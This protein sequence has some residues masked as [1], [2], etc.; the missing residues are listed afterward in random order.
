VDDHEIVLDMLRNLLEPEFEIVGVASCGM[1][2]LQAAQ[3]LHPDIILLDVVMPGPNGL[4]VGQ[5]LRASLP[6]VKLVYLT[7]EDDAVLAATAFAIGASGFVVKTGSAAELQ[8]AM[9]TVVDGKRYLSLE[10]AHGDVE[11]LRDLL[12]IDPIARLTSRELEVLKLLLSGLPMKSV[13]RR[14]GITP[15]TVAFHKYRAMEDLG[16][17]NNEELVEFAIR[18]GLLGGKP[19]VTR[20]ASARLSPA[21]SNTPR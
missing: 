2:A 6:G 3:R 21:P 14:L 5:K 10:I 12:P 1:S 19:A 7:M 9:R 8:H 16:L 15:R 13:A 20:S 11:A 4:E 17:Q 18:H